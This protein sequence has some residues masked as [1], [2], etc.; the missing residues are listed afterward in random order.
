VPCPIPRV[1]ADVEEDPGAEPP[2]LLAAA[3]AA[4]DRQGYVQTFFA[5]GHLVGRAGGQVKQG[6]H[7]QAHNHLGLGLLHVRTQGRSLAKGSVN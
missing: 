2:D 4:V 7:N 6:G 5:D 1:S 3:R